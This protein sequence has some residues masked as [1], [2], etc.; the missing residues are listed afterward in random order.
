MQN[1]HGHD[2][3]D[4]SGHWCL[5]G[6]SAAGAVLTLVGRFSKPVSKVLIKMSSFDFQGGMYVV[7]SVLFRRYR[8]LTCGNSRLKP[9]QGFHIHGDRPVI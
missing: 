5:T 8:D 9:V 3:S 4:A 6:D 1:D 2:S 7:T